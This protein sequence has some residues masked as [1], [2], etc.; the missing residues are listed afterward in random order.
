VV[1]QKR[2]IVPI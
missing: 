1:I 2:R